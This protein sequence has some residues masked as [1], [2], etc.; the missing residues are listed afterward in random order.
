MVIRQ[1]VG[2]EFVQV[3]AEWQRLQQ[4]WHLEVACARLQRGS[5]P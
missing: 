3:W 1:V 2:L 5:W 4:Q